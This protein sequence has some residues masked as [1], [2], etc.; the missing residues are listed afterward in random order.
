MAAVDQI[1]GFALGNAN[2]VFANGPESAATN[3][4]AMTVA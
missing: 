4:N 1:Q 3:T 2:S